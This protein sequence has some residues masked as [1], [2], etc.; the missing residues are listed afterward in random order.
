MAAKAAIKDCGRAMDM[1]YGEV[2][3]IAKLVPAHQ[4]YAGKVGGKN[5]FPL[6]KRKLLQGLS[7]NHAGVVHQDVDVPKSRHD[8]SLRPADLILIRHV[9]LKA[10]R[11]C[12]R[13]RHF[14]RYAA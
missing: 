8:F 4:K 1:Q 5:P 9:G 7:N 6:F 14:V 12:A 10:L 11:F 2:D 3:R 13:P